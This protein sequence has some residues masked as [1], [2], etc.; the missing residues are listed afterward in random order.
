MTSESSNGAGDGHHNADQVFFLFI[1]LLSGALCRQLLRHVKLPYTVI[2]LL[3]G[4]SLGFVA[5]VNTFVDEITDIADVDPHLV[6]FLFL[7]VLHGLFKI[8]LALTS[9]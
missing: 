8:V 7:P 3:L 4:I 6:L 2:L 5:K 1:T 9:S